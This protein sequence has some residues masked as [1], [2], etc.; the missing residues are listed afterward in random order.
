[1]TGFAALARLARA[2]CRPM[3]EWA[4]WSAFALLLLAGAGLRAYWTA[5]LGVPSLYPDSV[6]YAGPAFASPLLPLGEVRTMGTPYLIAASLAVFKHPAGLLIANNL[7][8]AL[9]TVAA[10]LALGRVL[11]L[12]VLSLVLMAYLAFSY[13]GLAAEY[14]LLSDHPAR[15][16]GLL[17]FT[18]LI[19]A[20]GAPA[21]RRHGAL[22]G[23]LAA[24]A[25]LVRPTG[26][27]LV[28]A[29]CIFYG[30]AW[31]RGERAERPRI[32]AGAL[33][34]LAI[35]VLVVWAN[36]A[37][38]K[39]HYGSFNLTHFSGLN[40]FANAGHLVDLDGP[41][42]PEIKR[43]L[44]MVLPLYVEKYVARG[45]HRPNWLTFG[46]TDEEM[47]RDF[48]NIYPVIII[49]YYAQQYPGATPKAKS[50]TVLSE[51]VLEG[52]RAHPGAYL[53]RVAGNLGRN[54]AQVGHE[55][56]G[57]PLRPMDLDDHAKQVGMFNNWVRPDTKSRPNFSHTA[58]G[59]RVW[60]GMGEHPYHPAYLEP[61]QRQRYANVWAAYDGPRRGVA[62]GQ[63]ATPALAALALLAVL[64]LRR[65]APPDGR[66]VM[67]AVLG[68][69]IVFGHTL[70]HALLNSADPV[71]YILPV[72]D[73]WVI[74]VLTLLALAGHALC[75]QRGA[76]TTGST[77]GPA[78]RRVDHRQ[79]PD[80]VHPQ[81]GGS[82]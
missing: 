5:T 33:L 20:S 38:F 69:L 54:L 46:V 23:L 57:K 62:A 52:I 30:W 56:W 29:L 66:L 14:S 7:L 21:R 60:R 8:W 12:R 15:I 28:V 2:F 4:Y 44:R 17:F 78:E 41:A 50:N 64:L 81:A 19:L 42:Y 26:V 59:Q 13:P 16:A 24:L 73:L 75:G 49:N 31:L 35:P 47:K 3:P 27:V 36:C 80:P 1:M 72:Q 34:G 55:A 71:R 9:S 63:A 22:L 82:V 18:A 45:D 37:V 6:G 11:G 61:G 48:G 40:L 43:A 67:I 53:E 25:I 76:I 74:V 65:A 68:G 70:L 77:S 58:L 51:L 32:A 10:T 39:R 79:E